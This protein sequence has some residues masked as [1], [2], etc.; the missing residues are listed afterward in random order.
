[1]LVRLGLTLCQSIGLPSGPYQLTSGSWPGLVGL[2]GEER[3]AADVRL[4]AAERDQRLHEAEHLGVALDQPPVE[5]T[6]GVV[7]AVGVVVA[8]LG[9]ADFVAGERSSAR[10][11]S[12]AARP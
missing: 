5:P 12:T 6:D 3:A 1:M 4:A 7:L 9:A 10:P 2:A 8:A 11:G